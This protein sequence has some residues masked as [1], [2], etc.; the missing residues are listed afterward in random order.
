M[1][2]FVIMEDFPKDRLNLIG[3]SP[4]NPHALS[5]FSNFGGREDFRVPGVEMPVTGQVP[6]GSIFAVPVN[7]ISL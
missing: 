2:E 3:A 1:D 5:I 4:M 7:T 6:E